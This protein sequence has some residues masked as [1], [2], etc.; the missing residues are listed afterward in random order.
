MNVVK[1]KY[2]IAHS[3]N[4]V[5]IVHSKRSAFNMRPRI[6]RLMI[7]NAVIKPGRPK[8]KRRRRNKNNNHFHSFFSSSFHS[9][10]NFVLHHAYHFSYATIFSFCHYLYTFRKKPFDYLLGQR[11]FQKKSAFSIGY[12]SDVGYANFEFGPKNRSV[13]RNKFQCI[14]ENDDIT[15]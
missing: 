12:E 14:N 15:R 1:K 2:P 4:C 11:P 3:M 10:P 13:E 8:R 7:E 5:N 6:H 9:K